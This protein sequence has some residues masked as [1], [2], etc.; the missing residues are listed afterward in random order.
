MND[1][2]H[3]T[4]RKDFPDDGVLVPSV[5]GSLAAKLLVFVLSVIAGSVDI[6]GFLGLGGLFVAH[7][8]GNIVVLAARLVAGDQASLAHLIAVPL[9]VAALA[10][11]RLLATGLERIRISSLMPLLLLQFVLLLGF[12]DICFDAGRSID[13]NSPRMIFAGMLG[14][15]AMAVQNALVRVSLKGAPSTAVMTTNITLFT[16]DVVRMLL[17]GDASGVAGAR[18]RAGNTWPA[19]AGFFLGCILGAACEAALGLRSLELP[20]IL[21]LFAIAFGLFTAL[22]DAG[23]D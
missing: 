13:P 22:Q 14:V 11:S 3:P 7:I 17:R 8:T 4:L 18:H 15:S 2:A 20:A 23:F 5:D 19:I 6:I 9:F 1:G 21:A 12:F 10:L 16:M